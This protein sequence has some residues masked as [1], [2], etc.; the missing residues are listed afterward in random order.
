MQT[1]IK[2]LLSV[3]DAFGEA[4]NLARSSVSKMVFGDGKT[5]D[6]ISRG[7]DM[8]IGRHARAMLFF[9]EN[10]PEQTPWPQNVER[11]SRGKPKKFGSKAA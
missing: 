7:A 3:A 10:W 4:K 2:E 6:A 8:T 11:P 5:L 1:P 9:S